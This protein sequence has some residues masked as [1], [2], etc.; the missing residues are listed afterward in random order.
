MYYSLVIY[1]SNNNNLV[2]PEVKI[3]GLRNLEDALYAI[4][5]GSNYLGIIC[6]PNRK[7]TI[8]PQV[9]K[10]I[11]ENV[12]ITEKNVKLVGVFRNQDFNGIMN[13]VKSYNLDIVQLHGNED[14]EQI[15]KFIGKISVIKRCVFPDDCEM[16]LT[17]SKNYGNNCK[18]LFDTDKGGT[19]EM[20][21]WKSIDTWAKNYPEF[22]YILAGGL[23]PSNVNEAISLTGCIGVD[24]SG[25]V[26]DKI[27]GLK[28][29]SK[30]KQFIDN[31]KN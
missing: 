24:V 14:I 10:K 9:A 12:H 31:A 26:E 5:N 29:H 30:I 3:C 1:R 17:I 11:S 15:K 4:D 13:L 28:A 7:R 27:T 16:A 19:G 22:H 18:I 6:V 25:G 2:M 20:L 23:T 21:D 8:D